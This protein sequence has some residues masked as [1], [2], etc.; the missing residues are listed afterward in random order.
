MTR[1]LKNVCLCPLCSIVLA[2]AMVGCG[3]DAKDKKINE[4][5]AEIE[6]LKNDLNDRDKQLNEGLVRDN[7][8]RDTIDQLNAKLAKMTAEGKPMPSDGSWMSTANFD[9]MSLSDSVLFESGKAALTTAGKAKLKQIAGEIKSKFGDRDIYIFG[10]TDSQPIKKSGW[11][12][13]WELSAQRSLTVVRALHEGGVPYNQLIAASCAEYR[14]IV[15]DAAKKDQP[16]NRR[17]EFFAVRKG[18]G[19]KGNTVTRGTTE[20]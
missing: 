17:V 20:E 7:D 16:R 8:A 18:T 11:K 19:T 2:V 14:P 13:N 10:H 3:P 9:M 4:L 6:G 1:M 5:T 12:D 15:Q